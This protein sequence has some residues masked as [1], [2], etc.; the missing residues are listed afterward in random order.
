MLTRAA[1]TFSVVLLVTACAGRT[2]A[3]DRDRNVI[4]AD[5]IATVEVTTAYDVVSRLRPEF[6]R[7]RGPVSARADRPMEQPSIT[8]FLDGVESGPVE[9]TLYL[10]PAREVA[11]IRLYRAADAVTKY[12][13]RHTGGV[14][15]VTTKRGE[16]P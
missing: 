12:G 1:L 2:R 4:T 15:A 10:I 6:L 3:T 9:R 11:E 8:V 14:I 13:S 5:E 7:T 16:K